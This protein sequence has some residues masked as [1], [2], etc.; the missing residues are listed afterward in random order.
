MIDRPARVMIAAGEA[1][2]DLYGGLLMRSMARGPSPAG[3]RGEGGRDGCAGARRV[4]FV[5]VG[6]PSMRDAGLQP[7]GDAGSWG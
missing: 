7:V 2:G 5:G 4:C 1:S 3:A 6:G